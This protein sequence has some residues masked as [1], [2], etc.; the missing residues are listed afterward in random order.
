[1]SEGKGLRQKWKE[2][3]LKKRVLGKKEDKGEAAIYR[4]KSESTEESINP[5]PIL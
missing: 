1:M 4:G 2:S 5:A 3:E